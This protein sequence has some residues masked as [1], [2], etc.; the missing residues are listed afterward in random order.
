MENLGDG[1]SH[2]LRIASSVSANIVFVKEAES[3]FSSDANS[4]S[5]EGSC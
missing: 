5:R 4:I 1:C 2:F 3:L